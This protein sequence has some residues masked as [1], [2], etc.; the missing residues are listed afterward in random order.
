MM[1]ILKFALGIRFD[2][3][4]VFIEKDD[5]DAVI[6]ELTGALSR[7]DVEGLRLFGGICK[8]DE[9]DSAGVYT[10][11]FMNGGIKQIRALYRKING[12]AGLRSM[13]ES[14]EPYIQNNVIRNFG[15]MEFLGEVGT[16]GVCA[17]G[18][19]NIVFPEKT[20]KRRPASE[21]VRVVLA[22]NAFKG[23][24]TSQEAI[25]RLS[26]A[27]RLCSKNVE[28]IPIPVADGGDGT[29][30][31]IESAVLSQRRTFAVTGPYGEKIK[32]DYLVTDGIRAVIE[33]ALASGL[34]VS[35][36]EE[37]DPLIA[38][39]CGT[40]ELI[41]RAAHEGVREIYV[42]LGGSATNDCGIGLARELG[43]FF[44][45]EEGKEIEKASDMA[46]IVSI[47][48]EGLDPM[49]KAARVTVMCDVDN[50]L[51]GENGATYVFGPQ[52]GADEAKLAVLEAGMVNMSKLLNSLAGRNVSE[53][54]GAGAAGGMGAMLMALL[55]ARCMSGADALLDIAEFDRKLA[56]AAL[57]VTGEG[58]I[59][60]TSLRGKALG[61]IM[62]RA[63]KAGV[64]VAVIAGCG[65]DGC[66][67]IE[68][69]AV[70]VEYTNSEEDAL[71]HFDEAATRLVK[72]LSAII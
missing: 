54:K 41:M 11:V 32:A 13:L 70:A 52:K 71:R 21:L 26:R 44:L 25:R 51:T 22:P 58:R 37:L 27:L 9:R 31:A 38:S 46:R 67:Q 29:L 24:I 10:V 59:D 16:D 12:D 60:S 61:R 2:F 68:N 45:D 49:V 69:R 42:G 48:T 50:P 34:A 5:V 53:E 28:L 57:V 19:R 6:V 35:R 36:A 64:P 3:S 8:L 65:G 33:S 47:D 4:K 14:R 39:S 30:S 1:E 18:S 62:E 66:E 63:E 55:S 17:G 72:K 56:G 43:V 7:K 20:E 15:E 40:G 23:T